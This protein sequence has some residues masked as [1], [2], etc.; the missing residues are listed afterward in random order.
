MVSMDSGTRRCV[1]TVGVVA[2]VTLSLLLSACDKAVSPSDAFVIPH[3]EV[4]QVE[5]VAA[6]GDVDAIKRLLAHMETTNAPPQV[7]E[8]WRA[9]AR[10][11]GD[12]DE[13]H[14]HAATLLID[15]QRERDPVCRGRLLDEALGDVERALATRDDASSRQLQSMIVLQRGRR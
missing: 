15:A 10:R 2:T 12:P 4:A 5:R 3:N 9:E 1:S 8:R 14:A 6:S 7:V 13:L 11:R